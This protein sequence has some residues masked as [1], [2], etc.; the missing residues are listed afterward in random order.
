MREGIFWPRH[1]NTIL[2]SVFLSGKQK[3]QVHSIVK[4]HLQGHQPKCNLKILQGYKILCL[5]GGYEPISLFHTPSDTC[6]SSQLEVFIL[7]TWSF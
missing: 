6:K 5:F 4:K 7:F 1:K 2:F 3:N